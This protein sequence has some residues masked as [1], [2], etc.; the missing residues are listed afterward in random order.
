MPWKRRCK[1]VPWNDSAQVLPCF[2]TIHVV[3]RLTGESCVPLEDKKTIDHCP[4]W[5]RTELTV[6]SSFQALAFSTYIAGASIV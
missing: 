1:E 6:I 4:F 5:G 2:M 3:N